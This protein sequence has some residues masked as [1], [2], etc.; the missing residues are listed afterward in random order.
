M[1]D[2]PGNQEMIDRL[3]TVVIDVVDFDDATIWN[4]AHK[5]SDDQKTFI[6]DG[7]P[8]ERK[9]AHPE[10][11]PAD[12]WSPPQF[13]DEIYLNPLS[14][15]RI[16]HAKLEAVPRDPATDSFDRDAWSQKLSCAR[17]DKINLLTS[18]LE[19]YLINIKYTY[20]GEYKP[21]TDENSHPPE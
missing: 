12:E 7:E 19:K 9:R 14:C 20:S 2:A 6:I 21:S 3:E 13:G 1:A 8:A 15:I 16:E 18:I 4:A 17:C 11:R 5:G 10:C